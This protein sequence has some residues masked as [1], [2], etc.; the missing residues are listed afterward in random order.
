MLRNYS[1]RRNANRYLPR[2]C[3]A[4]ASWA[5]WYWFD[6]NST[7]KLIRC[8][9]GFN[10]FWIH[11]FAWLVQCARA[12]I[13]ISMTGWHDYATMKHYSHTHTHTYI[14]SKRHTR[15]NHN[16]NHNFLYSISSER[17]DFFPSFRR[18]VWE[19]KSI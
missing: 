15:T 14:G 1:C 16:K 2:F 17:I 13:H 4:L 19:L 11:L 7:N 10:K 8:E 6:H 12:Y 3:A 5:I 18:F 9:T